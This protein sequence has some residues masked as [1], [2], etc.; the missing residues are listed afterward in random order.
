MRPKY[1]HEMHSFF[2]YAQSKGNFI[3]LKKHFLGLFLSLSFERDL[4]DIALAGLEL[5]VT[6]LAFA[7]WISTCLGFLDD[8][9]KVLYT[10][11]GSGLFYVYEYFA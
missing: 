6:S 11:P 8:K 4:Y 10:I 9:I 5:T 1:K 2:V 7:L 3:Y